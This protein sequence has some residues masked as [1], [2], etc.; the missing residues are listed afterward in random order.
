MRVKAVRSACALTLAAALGLAGCGGAAVAPPGHGSTDGTKAA[1]ST[2]TRTDVPAE[3]RDVAMQRPGP[4][5]T[6]LFT[7]DLLVY[8]Q[9][10]LPDDVVAAVKAVHGVQAAEQFSMAS[11]YVEEQE[12][13][14]AAV[15]PDTFRRYTPAA[16]A[17]DAEIWNRVADGEIGLTPTVRDAV[18]V[19]DDSV[20][21][22]NGQAPVLHIG[23]LA[24]LSE[25]TSVPFVKAVVN[26]RWAPKLHM[27]EGNALLISTGTF[28]PAKI[29]PQVQAL[30]GDKATV[31]LLGPAR[32]LDPH[33]AL[34]AVLT[35][36]SVAQALGSF[37]YTVNGDGSV[38]PD[39][40]WIQQY[41]RTEQVPILGAVRCNKA[42]LPQLR[43][44]LQDV[45]KLHLASAIHPSEYGGCYVPRYIGH[46][47]S[48]GLSF[49]TWGAAIDLNVPGNQRGT[50]G[51]IDR[52][53]VQI[54]KRWGFEWG[55]T[56]RYTDPMHF[57]MAQLV[58]V[59]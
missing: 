40:R 33:A 51:T 54:F 44:A 16:T 55:G 35:G 47:P 58:A 20:R 14:Y 48:Q 43:A 28:D 3:L 11:F 13:R 34:T 9:D 26:E 12:V 56:W 36:G 24:P 49:H 29:Q 38:N 5:K 46:D 17:Q 21:M 30:A 7:Q 2:P 8:S 32:Y 10:P 27:P 53:I 19:Q 15:D 59:R 25:Q 31:Q 42:M 50:V 6:P 39:Q 1:A 18:A 52:R 41:I 22:G 37:T 57:Q 23:A 45:V 4:V